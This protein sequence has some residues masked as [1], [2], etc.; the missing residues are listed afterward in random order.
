MKTQKF[1]TAGLLILALF[2]PI[3]TVNGQ[4][5]QKE[6]AKEYQITKGYTLGIDNK[7][8]SIELINWDRNE[9]SV[10][11]TIEAEATSVQRAES[12]LDKV[13]ID[14]SEEKSA[15][16]FETS[17]QQMQMNKE[18]RLKITYAVKAPAYL[19]AS[20]EQ[21]YGNIFI[22]NLTGEAILEVKY[23]NIDANSLVREEQNAVNEIT[24]AYGNGSIEEAGVMDVE[25][26][27]GN[28]SIAK[29][30]DLEIESGYSKVSLGEVN[31][32]NIDSK[33]DKLSLES[34]IGSA[35]I[36]SA[37]TQV[38]LGYI[39]ESFT[40][41]DA[42]MT[43]GNLKGELSSRAAFS[44]D[45][46]TAYGS[47]SVPDGQYNTEKDGMRQSVNGTIGRKSDAEVMVSIRYGNLNLK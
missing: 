47:I 4:K 34:L 6:V 13:T 27:Y 15:V 1:N 43:Y 36:S 14:I 17:F 39:S 25:I 29:S 38:D 5:A 16:Y 2:L 35:K 30:H 19:N 3:L 18:N 11:V 20:L 23:G 24:I 26:K 9:L 8:G 41:I 40:L 42:E 10:V 7:Y 45:A 31:H 37:Y 33:Y 46:E 28:L 21:S 44:I 22:Q 32:L 12:L